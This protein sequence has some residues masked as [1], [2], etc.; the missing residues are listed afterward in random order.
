MLKISRSS[1]GG[2]EIQIVVFFQEDSN[3]HLIKSPVNILFDLPYPRHL[4]RQSWV[5]TRDLHR[6]QTRQRLE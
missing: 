1:L 3:S 2:S 6:M 4:H 5:R